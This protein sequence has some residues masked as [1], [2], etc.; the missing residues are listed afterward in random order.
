MARQAETALPG[1][2]EPRWVGKEREGDGS[3][4]PGRVLLGLGFVVMMLGGLG[5]SP[6]NCRQAKLVGGCTGKLGSL[7][8]CIRDATARWSLGPRQGCG[9][10][11]GL[12]TLGGAERHWMSP[13]MHRWMCEAAGASKSKPAQRDREEK[14]LTSVTFLHRPLL[15]KINIML[16]VKEKRL[17]SVY[18]C[19]AGTEGRIGS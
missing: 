16:N 10:A 13:H 8:I 17:S 15:T 12:G 2:G 1:I 6:P 9:G 4:C 11:E 19:K 18:R 7:S 14:L 5:N 3:L